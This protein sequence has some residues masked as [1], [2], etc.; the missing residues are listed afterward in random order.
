MYMVMLGQGLRL[1]LSIF[2]FKGETV[3]RLGKG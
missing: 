1:E 2:L 3:D